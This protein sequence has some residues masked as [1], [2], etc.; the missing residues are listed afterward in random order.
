MRKG[1]SV[2]RDFSKMKRFVNEL[3]DYGFTGKVKIEESEDEEEILAMD[4]DG[5]QDTV[6]E[7]TEEKMKMFL[8]H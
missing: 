2:P 4:I 8:N 3:Y 1:Y 5:D 7:K 6:D